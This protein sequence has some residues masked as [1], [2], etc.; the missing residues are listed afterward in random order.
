MRESG[1][2][3]EA[4]SGGIRRRY[5]R[6]RRSLWKRKH[7]WVLVICVFIALAIVLWLISSLSGHQADPE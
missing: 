5:Y 1:T 2:S 6:K 7:F 4:A 3:S